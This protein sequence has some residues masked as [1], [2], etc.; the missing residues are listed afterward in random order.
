MN[1]PSEALE[2]FYKLDMSRNLTVNEMWTNWTQ[3]E[4]ELPAYDGAD[5]LERNADFAMVTIPNQAFV[6]NGGVGYG[7]AVLVNIKVKGEKGPMTRLLNN[8]T[9][10]FDGQNWSTIPSG[11][12]DQYFG[13]TGNY[14]ESKQSIYYWGGWNVRNNRSAD[15][16]FR[17]FDY[18]TLQWSF[19]PSTP[20]PGNSGVRFRHTA[21]MAGDDKIYFIG[22]TN[23]YYATDSISMQDILVYDTTADRWDLI[24]SQGSVTPS[25]RSMHTTTWTNNITIANTNKFVPV[26]D[27]CYTYDTVRNLWTLHIPQ[28]QSGADEIYGHSAV[29]IGNST[30]LIIFGVG[31]VE[32]KK[33][34]EQ[35]IFILDLNN[36]SWSE[37]YNAN[38]LNY[39]LPSPAKNIT[40]PEPTQTPSPIVDKTPTIIGAVVG[41]VGSVLLIGFAIGVYVFLRKRKA[42]YGNKKGTRQN[43]QKDASGHPFADPEK[44]ASLSINEQ[45]QRAS[46]TSES[47]HPTLADKP[48]STSPLM[49]TSILPSPLVDKP[50]SQSPALTSHPLSPLV[51]KP[52]SQSPI[53]SH[54]NSQVS[55]CEKPD[56]GTGH[57]GSLKPDALPDDTN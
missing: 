39:V 4:H 35:D 46:Q 30:L 2:G 44:M 25:E 19:S 38:A 50:A 43:Y 24:K 32:P 41:S 54:S 53:V 12:I 14:V 51:D 47:T 6:V 21:T 28:G 7:A 29:A 22:G 18:T 34:D 15:A 23:G 16:T 20:L 26:S 13:Q 10:K 27:Y 3:L 1:Y 36:M 17:I 45:G 42:K 52:F 57:R 31:P 5:P 56:S 40:I 33:L 55:L 8:Q 11:G 49:A 37:Q 48:L 9:T